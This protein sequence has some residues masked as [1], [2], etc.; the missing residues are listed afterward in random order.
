MVAGSWYQA[1]SAP[2]A[3][4]RGGLGRS[5][6]APPRP[7]PLVIDEQDTGAGRC[8]YA[9]L[10]SVSEKDLYALEQ[11]LSRSREGSERERR[12]A[13]LE[14]LRLGDR[15]VGR[16]HASS[17]VARPCGLIDPV[18]FHVALTWWGALSPGT[19]ATK[20]KLCAD[21]VLNVRSKPQV[22]VLVP[23]RSAGPQMVPPVQAA[24]GVQMVPALPAAQIATFVNNVLLI[25]W[26]RWS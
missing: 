14:D 8:P 5:S 25:C 10:R 20:L 12:A 6:I 26:N 16:S 17:H 15:D 18:S 23:V 22:H 1:D 9:A 21:N 11:R 19:C 2:S 4:K 7:P 13:V 3:R 24:C